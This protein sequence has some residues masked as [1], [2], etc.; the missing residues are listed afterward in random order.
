MA[1]TA[2]YLADK[3]ALARMTVAAVR[4]RLEPLLVEGLIASCGIINLELGYSARN[5]NTHEAVASERRSLPRATLDDEVY[6]RALEVQGLA[7]LA[8][9][10]PFA[11]TG[12]HH[13]CLYRAGWADGAPLR[14]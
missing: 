2:I 5:A 9:A 1:L 6:D 7:G 4:G 3:S 10:A 14:C 13:R 12:S 11:D 8:R